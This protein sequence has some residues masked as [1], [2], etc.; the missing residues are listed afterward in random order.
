MHDRGVEGDDREIKLLILTQW[1][2]PEPTIKG[3][4]FARELKRRGFNVEVVTGFPNY[5]GGHLYPG[6]RMKAYSREVLDGI[7]VTRLP[8][9]PS[10]DRS[11][12]RRIANYLSF[13]FVALIYLLIRRARPDVIYA[14]HPPLTV[15][16]AATV[17]GRVRRVPFIADVQDLWPDTLRATGL[18]S[19]P[20]VLR[21]VG[22]GCDFVYRAADR[23]VVLSP[24]LKRLLMDRGVPEPRLEVIYNWCDEAALAPD[25]GEAHMSIPGADRFK[26]VFAGNLGSAQGLDSVLDAAEIVARSNPH[27]QFIFVGEGL[28]K[29]RLV[30]SAR[31]RRLKTVVF[32]P[33]M[34]MRE[35]GGVLRSADVLLVHLLSDPL[36]TVTIPSKTQA[37]MSI[38]RP[39]LMAVTGDAA[40][41]VAQARCGITADAGSPESISRAA[42]SLSRMSANDLA[43]MGR[44]GA[45]AYA[46]QMSLAVGVDR[47]AAVFREVAGRELVADK[48]L[49]LMA[50]RRRRL[51]HRRG[52][53]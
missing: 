26:I 8:L 16:L 45:E 49:T 24:G 12:L 14:Y 44:R 33:R 50:D 36:F 23:I 28:E 42:L 35:I 48:L 29:D 2:D 20:S 40:D 38:G 52:D 32:L 51:G 5:P 11:A 27:V 18:V 6:Y 22:R 19:R 13:G 53:V 43:E 30:A 4:T 31:E 46:S 37:Y 9:Y 10:H 17:V 1:F 3:L 34:P 7:T 47:F 15:G 21:N 39:I 41:V 25:E